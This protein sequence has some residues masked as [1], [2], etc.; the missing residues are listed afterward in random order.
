VIKSR[1]K[2]DVHSNS[3]IVEEL[4]RQ[5]EERHTYYCSE[6]GLPFA[7]LESGELV[8]RAKHHGRGHTNHLSVELLALTVR[9]QQ[10]SRLRETAGEE[11]L[12]LLEALAGGLFKTSPQLGQLLYRIVDGLK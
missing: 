8:I 5:K 7:N 10:W 9:C 3:L 4:E 12:S 1:H 2:G 6:C 11:G